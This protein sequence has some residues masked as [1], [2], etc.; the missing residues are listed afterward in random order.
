MAQ[1][2]VFQGDGADAVL[3]GHLDGMGVAAPFIGIGIRVIDV[4]IVRSGFRPVAGF[5]LHQF[6]EDVLPV[7]KVLH[8]SG[9]L[10]SRPVAGIHGREQGQQHIGVVADFVQVEV[11]FVII[12]GAGVIIQI[13]LQFL[14]FCGIG[15]LR[16]QQRTVAGRVGAAGQNRANPLHNDRA[17]GN[18]I[19]KEHQ[20]QYDSKDNQEGL[21]TR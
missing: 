21:L 4:L 8:H 13:P 1:I 17:G 11:V 15:C 9:N 6:R 18:Y 12:M 14:L 20:K 16:I 2:P 10:R 5:R 7:K 19:Q 3:I